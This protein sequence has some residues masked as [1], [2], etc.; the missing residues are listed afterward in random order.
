[1]DIHFPGKLL[2]K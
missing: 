1:M 2:G